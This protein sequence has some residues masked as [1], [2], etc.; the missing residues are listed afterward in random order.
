MDGPSPT[1]PE[2]H[3]ELVAAILWGLRRQ[4]AERGWLSSVTVGASCEKE[5][6]EWTLDDYEGIRD[7]GTGQALDSARVMA[8]R[9][10]E[11]EFMDKLDILKDV[12][13]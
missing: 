4:L 3:E 5:P 11:L 13:L 10:E 7:S 6:M 12:P 1:G 9:R 8:A 2:L